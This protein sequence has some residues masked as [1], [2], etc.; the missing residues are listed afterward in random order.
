[1]AGSTGGQ[2]FSHNTRLSASA[3]KRESAAQATTRS[4]SGDSSSST[5][6]GSSPRSSEESSSGARANHETLTEAQIQD[7]KRAETLNRPALKGR[8]RF[9]GVRQ[10]PS[11]RWVSEIKDTTQKIRLW[12]GTFDT[13]EDAARAYDEAAWLL[14]GANTRTNFVVAPSKAADNSML[15]SK[16]ARL[17]LLRKNAMIAAAAA[18]A[19]PGSDSNGTSK[20]SHHANQSKVQS[21]SESFMARASAC[22]EPQRATPMSR[23]NFMPPS[24][25]VPGTKSL[26]HQGQEADLTSKGVMTSSTTPP[27]SVSSN[28]SSY[29]RR[30]MGFDSSSSPSHNLGGRSFQSGSTMDL[31]SL[32]AADRNSCQPVTLDHTTGMIVEER[33][34]VDIHKH[35]PENLSSSNGSSCRR[36]SMAEE[37]CTREAGMMHPQSQEKPYGSC[38]DGVH[39]NSRNK[40]GTIAA[41]F[42]IQGST[43][44]PQDDHNK[45]STTPLAQQESFDTDISSGLSGLED[46]DLG[47]VDSDFGFSEAE[48]SMCGTTNLS[49]FLN[50][51]SPTFPTRTCEN[52]PS[53]AVAADSSDAVEAQTSTQLSTEHMRQM[54]FG[55]QLSGGLYAMNGVQEC[56]MLYNSTPAPYCMSSPSLSL[57]PSFEK[58]SNLHSKSSS[59]SS[60]TVSSQ[61]WVHHS[62]SNISKG[63]GGGAEFAGWEGGNLVST[64]LMNSNMYNSESGTSG[65][66][67]SGCQQS[68]Y[69]S[70]NNGVGEH[71]HGMISESQHLTMGMGTE[72]PSPEA[73]WNSWDLTPLCPVI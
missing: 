7:G 2:T 42:Q 35:V 29:S 39:D 1:M 38:G 67:S 11:G 40:N 20:Q 44:T 14:R 15:P 10:R 43:V 54:M 70:S 64:G 58:S 34:E 8:R 63:G 48:I 32:K 28:P 46:V 22:A 30:D 5:F 49:N 25:P 33:G 45:N 55:R 53:C 9:V 68:E 37:R 4:N 31:R 59:I 52:S 24:T 56:L 18:A 66:F 13:A 73:L 21:L 6:T 51:N 72:G 71:T 26:Q 23:H 27:C 47:C 65:T 69:R 17:L 60:S 3:M 50:G 57:P 61:G 62:T 41:G 36:F 16:A 19:K 12:L